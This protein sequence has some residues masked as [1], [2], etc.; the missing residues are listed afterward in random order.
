MA[1]YLL[2]WNSEPL[3]WFDLEG[4]IK[5]IQKKGT[6]KGNWSCGVTKKIVPNDRIFLMKLGKDPRG[7]I[8]SGWTI[9]S[10]YSDEHWDEELASQGKKAVYV[11]IDFDTIL[12]PENIFPRKNL[13]KGIYSE[14]FWSPQAS[15][16]TIQEDIAEK[17]EDDWA[18]FLK[19]PRISREDIFPDEAETQLTFKEGAVKTVKVNYYERDKQARE[20]C[21]N[22]FGLDC[23]VCGFNFEENY[24][25]IGKGFIHVHHLKSLAE[26]GKEYELNPLKDLRPVCP[27]CHAML[28][29]RKPAFSI[30]ELVKKINR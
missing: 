6:L 14:M 26:I 8:A 5:E 22:H 7:I 16:V 27:N 3:N 10:S 17:L 15:G 12:K 29:K 4:D 18:K 19:R 13:E 25:E 20:V 28:H 1:T 2:T 21:I 11:E 23:G 9:S 24:G 30:E